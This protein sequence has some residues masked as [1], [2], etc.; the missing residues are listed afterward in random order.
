MAAASEKIKSEE[1]YG[2]EKKKKKIVQ[3]FRH[4]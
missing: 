1:V 2:F 3:L 4:Y